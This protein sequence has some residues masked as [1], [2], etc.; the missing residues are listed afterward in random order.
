MLDFVPS[1]REVAAVAEFA[2]PILFVVLAHARFEVRR[3]ACAAIFSSAVRSRLGGS[4]RVWRFG[5]CHGIKD[6]LVELAELGF[7]MGEVALVPVLAVGVVLAH[8]RLEEGV[9][10]T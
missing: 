8:H 1:V 2:E 6:G 7:A 5:A 3:S 4:L 9:Q 10:R